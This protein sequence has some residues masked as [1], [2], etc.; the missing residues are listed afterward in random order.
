MR[1]RT[2]NLT[3]KQR[4]ISMMNDIKETKKEEEKNLT[5][6]PIEYQMKYEM[7]YSLNNKNPDLN[8]LPEEDE[9]SRDTHSIES[10]SS[11]K[12]L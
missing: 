11:D 10:K 3:S 1:R 2:E 7:K 4:L 8:V 12:K 5:K 6:V 9:E